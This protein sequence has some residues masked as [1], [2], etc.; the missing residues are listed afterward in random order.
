MS[1]HGF[2]EA[3]R[4]HPVL[5]TI[6]VELVTIGE[7]A[8]SMNRTMHEAATSYQKELERRLNGLLSMLE[9]MSTLVVGG[10]V[11]FIAFSMFV[12]IYSGLEAIG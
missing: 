6:W 4:R 5:P 9:P 7:E 1:G 8:N 11:G 10:I 3:L 12:P 2:A